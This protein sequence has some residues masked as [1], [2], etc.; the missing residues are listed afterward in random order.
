MKT[1]LFRF[2]RASAV[3]V[4]AFALNVSSANAQQ[5][6]TA[7]RRTVVV[8]AT[9]SV[10]PNYLLPNGMTINQYAYNLSVLANAYSQ[11]PPWL[12]GYNP[13][14]PTFINSTIYPVVPAYYPQPYLMN[15]AYPVASPFTPL[16][17]YTNPYFSFFRSFP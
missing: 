16:G 13:Y 5:P 2:G 1:L 9:P 15:P 12:L 6:R 8:P 14:P 4:L 7:N 17:L 11:I 3:A 10:N